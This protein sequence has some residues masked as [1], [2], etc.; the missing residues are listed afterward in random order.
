MYGYLAYWN[1]DLNTVPWDELTHIATFHAYA[2]T[3]GTLSDTS[4]LDIAD[5]AV[6]MAAPYGVDV[7]LCA[8]NYSPTELSTLLSS[9]SSRTTL[10]NELAS[11]QAST[12]AHG[13]NIDFEGLPLDVRDEMVT[14]VIDLEPA[15]GDVVLATPSV[16]WAGSWNYSE[17]TDHADLFIMGYGYHWGG[18]HY[19]GPTDPLCAGGGTVWDG[20]NSYSLSWS[21]DD[22]IASG[23]DPDRIIMGLPHPGLRRHHEPVLRRS[24]PRQRGVR[25]AGRRRGRRLVSARL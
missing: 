19:A 17:L 6:A 3:D 1:D 23:A 13:I 21:L 10:I 11:W 16:D 24:R 14:F 8:T 4:R 9:S 18:S 20:V 2:N 25:A 15:V 22:Y 7:H 5:D 12:G